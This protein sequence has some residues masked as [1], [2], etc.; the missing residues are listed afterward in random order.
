MK[1][2]AALAAGAAEEIRD[3]AAGVDPRTFEAMLDELS[4][5]RRIV[6]CGAGREGLMMRALAMRLYHLGL[7]AHVAGDMSAPPVGPGDLLLV[8]AGP[9]YLSTIAALVGVARAAG[10]RTLCVTAEPTGPV[11]LACDCVLAIPAQT[12]ANDQGEAAKS[13]LPMGSLF[14]GA[15]FLVFELLVLALRERLGISPETMRSRH[16]NLE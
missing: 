14:E 10:A 1:E 13:V 7:D 12:M 2:F 9:G 11:P 6:A 4:R 5:A 16:T 8:S 15:Q 3:A